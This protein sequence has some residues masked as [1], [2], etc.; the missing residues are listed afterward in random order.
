MAK[1]KRRAPRG[2]RVT[3]PPSVW[4]GELGVPPLE[5]VVAALAGFERIADR[6][7]LEIEVEISSFLG[8][9]GAGSVAPEDDDEPDVEELINGVVEVCLHHLDRSPPRVVLDF[10]WVLD[11]FDLAYVRWPLHERLEAAALPSRPAWAMDVGQAEVVAAH[12]V[13][14]ETGDGYDVA[15]VARHRSAERDHVV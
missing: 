6:S 15:L 12:R 3:P 7:P 4:E 2:G 1:R 10:L 8:E 11:A 5:G 14:H 13:E 9:L